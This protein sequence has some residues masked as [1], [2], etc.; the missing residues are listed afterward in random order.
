[1]AWPSSSGAA[2]TCGRGERGAA[3]IQVAI[4][5]FVLF[6]MSA[7]VLDW[8]VM[9]LA[10]RQAQNAADAGALAGVI[11]RAFDEK[12]NTVAADGVAERAAERTAA[13]NQV[14]GT[15]AVSVATFSDA[16]DDEDPVCPPYDL[17]GKC[18]RVD[19]YRDGSNGSTAVPTFFAKLFGLNSQRIRATATAKVLA[20]NGTT[21]LKPWIVPDKFSGPN[22]PD[23]TFDPAVDTYDRTTT[24]YTVPD[25]I[26]ARVELHKDE[27]DTPSF[28]FNI[29]LDAPGG[30]AVRDAISGCSG[31]AYRIGDE[32]AVEPGA[33][34]GPNT[35]GTNDLVDLDPKAEWDV[36]NKQIKAGTSCAPGICAD[37]KY[38]S[39]SPRI[40]PV[41]L[42]S[43]KQYDDLGRPSGKFD[44][45]IVAFFS[46]FVLEPAP[47]AEIDGYLAGAVGELL[48][49]PPADDEGSFLVVP[50]LVR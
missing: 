36:A 38:Y 11:A 48:D 9:W 5:I 20:A 23:G 4:S 25:D 43:P 39:Q 28:Y 2:A 32:L 44:I 24:G 31:V 26:G 35:Q 18:V 27:N 34:V 50:T 47:K 29:V 42:F 3:L 49:G 8:G 6:A 10:R 41:A 22:W 33:A 13:A 14:I 1:M 40:V 15:A 45:K 37:G 17:G 46:F 16:S 12:G 30:D 7:F 19:V 21:C